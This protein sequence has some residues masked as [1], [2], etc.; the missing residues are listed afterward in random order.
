MQG[1]DVSAITA[2]AAQVPGVAV[3]GLQTSVSREAVRTAET[4][5]RAQVIAS[6]R[7]QA[8]DVAA[9][10]GFRGYALHEVHVG[11]QWPEPGPIPAM[12]VMAAAAEAAPVLPVAARC[13]GA[14]V[15]AGHG[16]GYGAAAV[17]PPAPRVVTAVGTICF[18]PPLA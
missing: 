13:A 16:I 14:H 10:F 6:F 17:T 8:Q 15:V 2:L 5:L 12:R 18:G 11:T 1:R 4:V 3:A 7:Q 9:A